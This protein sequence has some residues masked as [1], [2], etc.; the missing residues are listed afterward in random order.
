MWYLSWNFLFQEISS[1]YAPVIASEPKNKTFPPKKI[2]YIQF[3]VANSLCTK[4]QK[5][6]PSLFHKSWETSFLDFLD[7]LRL[8]TTGFFSKN[9]AA[10]YFKLDKI[11]TSCKKWQNFCDRISINTPDKHTDT[12]S[13]KIG[14]PSLPFLREPPFSVP[15]LS[16]WEPSKLVH[17]NCMKNF[18]MKE[19]HFVLY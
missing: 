1:F 19:L 6:H 7:L 5:Y 15:P 12:V 4:W 16:F 9:L 14:T 13:S 3:N 10:R 17:G 2:I 8:K 11:L 18:K